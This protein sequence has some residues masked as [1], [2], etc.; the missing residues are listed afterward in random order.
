MKETAKMDPPN[1]VLGVG[2]GLFLI[3][4]VWALSLFLCIVFSRSSGAISNLGIVMIL[5]AILF[6]IILLVLPR[7]QSTASTPKIYDYS[8]IYRWLLISG[9]ILFLLIGAIAYLALHVM[10][11]V[12]AKPIRKLRV[13]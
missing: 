12:Y 7:Q 13:S 11:P 9:C 3:V 1:T 8:I 5:V 10:E 2:V 4:F 6:T